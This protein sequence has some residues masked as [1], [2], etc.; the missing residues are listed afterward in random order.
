MIELIVTTVIIG[1]IVLAVYSLFITING[2]QRSSRHLDLATR[3]AE[4]RVES[5]RNNNYTL[6]VNGETIDFSDELPAD[7]PS[8]RSGSAVINEPIPG[9]KRV[10]VTITYR[11]SNRDKTVQLSSLIGQIGIGGQ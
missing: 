5:L 10:D 6:L 9:V 1:L 3:T 11:D 7:L 8:P 2:T 4:Q